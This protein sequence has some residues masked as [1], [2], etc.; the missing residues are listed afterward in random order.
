MTAEALSDFRHGPEG[1]R[2]ASGGG[3]VCHGRVAPARAEAASSS[4]GFSLCPASLATTATTT[5]ATMTMTTTAA[6]TMPWLDSSPF[7]VRM[8]RECG[9]LCAVAVRGGAG[10]DIWIW[11][12]WTHGRASREGDHPRSRLRRLTSHG[13]WAPLPAL[14][15]LL[16]YSM[17]LHGHVIPS[18]LA[19]ARTR[20]FPPDKQ[21]GESASGPAEKWRW[22]FQSPS[23]PWTSSPRLGQ[24]IFY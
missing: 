10:M 7:A 24:S 1:N 14:P 23:L 20:W 2:I 12:G 9:H 6:T 17:H 11:L 21:Q 8:G 13:P 5:T 19:P 22:P 15:T 18:L 16:Y 3:G 4:E